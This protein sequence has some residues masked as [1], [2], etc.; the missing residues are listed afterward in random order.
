MPL[1]EATSVS[2]KQSIAGVTFTSICFHFISKYDTIKIKSIVAVIVAL[3]SELCNKYRPC[4]PC[5]DE[6]YVVGHLLL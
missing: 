4:S 1:A 2:R 6:M 3:N 5:V